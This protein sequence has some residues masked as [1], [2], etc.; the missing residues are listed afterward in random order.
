MTTKPGEPLHIQ[1]LD[2]LKRC[3][4]IAH[5]V[6]SPNVRILSPK[7]SKSSLGLMALKSGMLPR[8]HGM[9]YSQSLR[10]HWKLLKMGKQLVVKGNG[11]MVNSS[12]QQEN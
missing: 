6:G 11:T 12:G 10:Q 9:P 2:R 4:E 7:K 8:V 3:M 1:H 5:A